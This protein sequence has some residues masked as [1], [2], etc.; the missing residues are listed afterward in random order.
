VAAESARLA[1][2]GCRPI[3][4]ARSGPIS[5]AWHDGGPLFPHPIEVHQHNDVI[6][7]MHGRLAALRP[8]GSQ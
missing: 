1:R 6:A 2:L 7:A 5:V 8:D 3:N 4:T